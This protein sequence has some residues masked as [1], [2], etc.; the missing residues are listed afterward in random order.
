[1]IVSTSFPIKHIVTYSTICGKLQGS[2][3]G[4]IRFII[5]FPVAIDAVAAP[6]G[7]RTSRVTSITI[8]RFMNPFKAKSRLLFM[9]P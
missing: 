6:A 2:M 8:K 4:L 9:L 3:V 1:M 7:K 5:V